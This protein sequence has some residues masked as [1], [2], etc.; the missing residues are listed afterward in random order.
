MALVI[1]FGHIKMCERQNVEEREIAIS[2]GCQ[3]D[4]RRP[5]SSSAVMEPTRDSWL[6]DD[7]P[8]AVTS[9]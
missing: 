2:N 3:P 7:D 4:G 8:A 6:T 5:L 1:I 9:L